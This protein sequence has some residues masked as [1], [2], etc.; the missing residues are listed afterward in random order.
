[1]NIKKI[2]NYWTVT[3]EHHYKTAKFLLKGKRYPECL[4]FCHLMIEK[5]LKAL[6][7]QRTKTHAPHIHILVDLAK[8][9]KIDLSPEQIDQL[10]TIT[11]FNIAA[12]YNEIKFNFYKRCNKTYT[13]RYFTISK[14]LYL[15]LKKQLSQKK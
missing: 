9:A 11:E 15:W 3:A 14:N 6:I 5:I 1:V 7:V 10:T 12:R 13:E 4:F 8:L 2:I